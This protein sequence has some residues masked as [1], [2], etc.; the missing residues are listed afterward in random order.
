[1]SHLRGAE[2]GDLG[3]GLTVENASERALRAL[4]K[5]AE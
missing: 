3:T 5:I 1:M 2:R 4:R